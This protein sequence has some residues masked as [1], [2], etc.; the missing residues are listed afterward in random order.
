MNPLSYHLNS[1]HSNTTIPCEFSG[2]HKDAIT[3]YGFLE[4]DAA[5]LLTGSKRYA[6]MCHLHLQEFKLHAE[7][8]TLFKELVNLK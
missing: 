6:R 1:L 2:F 4:C 8:R 3:D 5:L 7:W